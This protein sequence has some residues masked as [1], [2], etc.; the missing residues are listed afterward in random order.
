MAPRPSSAWTVNR[1]SW[2][3]KL[4]LLPPIQSLGKYALAPR[5]PI[6]VKT[7]L[8]TWWGRSR[9]AL[10]PASGALRRGRDRFVDRLGLASEHLLIEL[11]DGGFRNL[12]DDPD[13]V[14][15]PP[16]GDLA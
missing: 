3:I 15:E 10:P 7:V 13:L 11:A 8:P 14:R 1:P 6:R 9:R 12:V 2:L 16:L 4:P 5:S